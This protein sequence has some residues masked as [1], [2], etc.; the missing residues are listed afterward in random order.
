MERDLRP[1][2]RPVSKGR[3]LNVTVCGDKLRNFETTCSGDATEA[4]AWVD[5]ISS[6]GNHF[7]FLYIIRCM[8]RNRYTLIVVYMCSCVFIGILYMYRTAVLFGVCHAVVYAYII[9]AW[10]GFQLLIL[11]Q[12]QCEGLEL[13]IS[14]ERYILPRLFCFHNLIVNVMTSWGGLARHLVCPSHC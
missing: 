4:S 10:A 6:Y 5:F 7:P 2:V 3:F 13:G 11:K 12:G 1:F 9:T 14:A 8:P